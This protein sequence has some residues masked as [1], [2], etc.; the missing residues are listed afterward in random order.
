MPH[1]YLISLAREYV[2]LVD[3]MQNGRYTPEELRTLD[4]ERQG[5]HNQLIAIVGVQP[6]MYTYARTVLLAA[7]GRNDQ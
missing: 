5:A 1:P 6:N 7:K 3:A 4:S 2:D